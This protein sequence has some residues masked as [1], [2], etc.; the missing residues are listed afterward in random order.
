MFVIGRKRKGTEEVPEEEVYIVGT[1]GNIYRVTI[2]KEPTC[3]CPDAR[4]GNQC[5]HVV[6]VLVNVL[7]APEHLRYQLAFLSSELREIFAKAPPADPGE[8]QTEKESNNRK[9]IE[10]DCPICFMEFNPQSEEIIYCRT[11]C[12]NNVHK[13]CFEQWAA[14]TANNANGIRC[15]YCRAPWPEKTKKVDIRA[16]LERSTV[17]HEGYINV[18][19]SFGLSPLRD[20]STYY[21]FRRWGS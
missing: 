19:E 12:G 16:A 5:K 20:Y 10:G 7:K 4:K 18:A 14:T 21:P 3:T 1:T 6:Y 17:S 2:A 11:S 9:P 13:N 8:G 15:V